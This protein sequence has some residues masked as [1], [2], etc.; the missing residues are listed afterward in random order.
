MS[1]D[2]QSVVKSPTPQPS[3]PA[4]VKL[5]EH[6]GARIDGVRLGGDL[7]PSTVDLIYRALLEHKV[8]FFRDQHQLTDDGQQAFAKLIG[9]PTIA[10]PTV[11]S[12]GAVILPVDSDYQ[13]ANTWHSDV[14]FVDRIPKASI[15]RAVELPPYGGDT[16]WASGV[17]AY[18]ALPAPLKALAE[19]LRAVHSN[20]YDYATRAVDEG[21]APNYQDYRAEFESTVY[22]TEHP[23]VR[24]HPETG[25]RTLLLGHFVRRFVDLPTS[26]SLALFRLLQGYAVDED[27]TV[28][29]SWRPGDVAIWDNRATQHRAV[30]DYGGQHRRLHRITLAGDVPIGVDG[31]QSSVLRGDAS[32]YSDIDGPGRPRR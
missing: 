30:A 15:L 25:E 22:E 28:R 13:S 2:L 12:R 17:A 5:G 29:W 4:V 3:S 23:V 8:I 10:H 6:L 11:T 19:S 18:A 7:D 32:S 9:T 26:A 16:I 21:L 1:T 27:R 24:I 20:V 31:R 14:T